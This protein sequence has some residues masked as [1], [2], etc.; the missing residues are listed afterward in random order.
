MDDIH[1]KMFYCFET[2]AWHNI[3][4]PSMVQRTATEILTEEFKG[5]ISISLR[6]VTVYLNDA[7]VETG[8]YA[9]V[10]SPSSADDL[11]EIVFGYAT[12]RYHPLQPS[13]I[14]QAFDSNVCEPAE[15]MFFLGKGQEMAISWKMPSFAVRTGDEVDMYGIVKS[16]FDTL[17]GTSLFTSIYR[18]VCRNTLTLAEGWAKRNADKSTGKGSIWKGKAV[19]KNLLRD[20]GYWFAHVQ[21][22]A[23]QEANLLQDFFGLLAKT[24]IKNDKEV[25]EIL[26]EAYPNKE[27]ISGFYPPEL[28][29]GKKGKTEEFNEKQ[30]M[31]R[32]GIGDVFYNTGTQISN[33]LYGCLNATTE[34]FCNVMPSKRPIAAS[35]MFGDRQKY[36]ARMVD[37]LKKRV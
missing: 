19:N 8:D 29:V 36:M 20:L 26:R 6:P 27:D 2:P 23:I 4:K 3:V 18:P 11:G 13:E 10:R 34:Y 30:E 1:G 15:T 14:A 37:T 35:V 21:G 25:A 22:K 12:D 9:I 32:V 17:K 24:P 7:D 33:D 16:G 28:R 5:G 31:I